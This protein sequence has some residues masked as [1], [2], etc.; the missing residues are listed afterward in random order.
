M[1][2]RQRGRSASAL[3]RRRRRG[4][5]RLGA[6]L[7]AGV[8]PIHH[9]ENFM[10]KLLAILLG[11][12][13]CTLLTVGV[14]GCGK[15]KDKDK[16]ETPTGKPSDKQEKSTK[17]SVTKL[18]FEE[19]KL[20]AAEEG[21]KTVESKGGVEIKAE[22]VDAA[23]DITFEAP[24]GVKIEKVTIKKGET[25]ADVTATIEKAKLQKYAIKATA[26]S[27]DTKSAAESA[28]IVVSKKDESPPPKKAGELSLSL[29]FDEVKDVSVGDKKV[30]AKG[31]LKITMK[32]I[33]EAA[34]VSIAKAPKGMDV[35]VGDVKDGVAAVTVT[36][37][38]VTEKHIGAHDVTLSASA[39]G[40]TKEGSAK[41]TVK[42]K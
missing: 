11:L 17:L 10:R 1:W 40:V 30:E 38:E 18:W 8:L 32:N 41:L 25:K 13:L 4:P 16:T 33:D 23:V 36:I 2:L 34:T 9:K 14:S 29:S 5:A 21:K 22:N 19:V 42:K 26:K 35:K 28:D 24:D 15:K 3:R 37:A 20:P 6:V 31:S 27:G 39:G 7:R 12:G